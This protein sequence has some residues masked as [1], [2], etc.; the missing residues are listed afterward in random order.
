MRI[1]FENGI[2][3]VPEWLYMESGFLRKLNKNGTYDINK[4]IEKKR[5]KN[6]DLWKV[7]KMEIREV[8]PI[9][10][11]RYLS[12][13]MDLF[14]LL[15]M[16]KGI[17]DYIVPRKINVKQSHPEFEKCLIGLQKFGLSNQKYSKEMIDETIKNNDFKWL[18][19][20]IKYVDHRD[21]EIWDD[22]SFQLAIQHQSIE[23]IDIIIEYDIYI[24][25][26]YL[27]KT[28]G[29]SDIEGMNADD[30]INE[31]LNLQLKN[32]IVTD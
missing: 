32:M 17:G 10:M 30:I 21:W 11:F 20:G 14:V 27:D 16:P 3:D 24:F 2:L 19:W 9:E 22:Y 8:N 4:L 6:V 1:T 7:F 26:E 18:R 15:E 5:F 12:H 28:Y 23:C 29:I 31:I 13:F 25:E